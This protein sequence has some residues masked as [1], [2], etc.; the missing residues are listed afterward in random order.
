M[1]KTF[2]IVNPYFSHD[3]DSRADEKI[4]KMFFEYRRNK[5]K[6]GDIAED[7]L[8]FAAYGV[9][10]AVVEYM[11][12]NELKVSEVEMLADEFRID[13]DFLDSILTKFDLFRVEEDMFINDRIL[14]NINKQE[15]KSNKNK[16]CA[17]I[18]WLFSAYNKSYKDEFGIAPILD[19]SE[20]RKLIEY[21]NKIENF[22]ELLPDILYTL[23]N[24]KFDDDINFKPTSNWL[25]KGN[26]LAQILNGQWGKL[27]HKK[28]PS[29]LRAEQKQAEDEEKEL[30]EPGPFE[31]VAE[32][33]SNKIDAIDLLCQESRLI[34]GRVCVRPS[35]KELQ[36]RFD[37]TDKE[38]KERMR[39]LKNG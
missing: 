26:N 11:H 22:R 31:K 27:K 37:I 34:S 13:S 29:E 16:K 36:I 2:E 18:R 28:T 38:I 10:W 25:L 17:N 35:L 30:S 1:S 3:V 33:I 9:Y 7:L 39:D 14:R 24:I 20:K 23:H 5:K 4:I 6:F 12:K 21:S 8:P 15:E 32:T 19:D